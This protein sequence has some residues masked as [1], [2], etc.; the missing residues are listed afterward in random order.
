V[1]GVPLLNEIHKAGFP[2]LSVRNLGWLIVH[3]P[4]DTRLNVPSEVISSINAL[5][6]LSSSASDTLKLLDNRKYFVA[7]FTSR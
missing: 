1:F 6:M 3:V 7:Y 2:G 5:V 4:S